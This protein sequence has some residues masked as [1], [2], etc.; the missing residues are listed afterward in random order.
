MRKIAHW[1]LALTIFYFW[2]NGLADNPEEVE[3]FRQQM[4]AIVDKGM[5]AI[6]GATS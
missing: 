2:V 1:A 4:N 3:A 6:K 5:S